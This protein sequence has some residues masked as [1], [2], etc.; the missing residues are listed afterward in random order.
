AAL[1]RQGARARAPAAPAHPAPPVAAGGDEAFDIAR[2]LA[3]ELGP[4]GGV[5][6]A[7]DDFQY[8]VE[9]VF[10]QFKKGV[11]ETVKPED[12]ETH[13]DLGIAYKEMGL[14]DDAIHEFEVAL[15]GHSKKKEV[16]CLSMIGLCHGSRGDHRA[17][18]E[19]FRRALRSGALTA[20]SAKA[21]HYELAAA[22]EALGQAEQALWYL[23]KIAKVDP[24]YRDAGAA[25]ARLGGGPGRPPVDLEA[26]A[27]VRAAAG[28]PRP[29]AKKNIGYV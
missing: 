12:T 1:E 27:A 19:V 18:V 7:T 11:A 14:L 29:G 16:D 15:T 3:E 22:H 21:I 13:Y 20:D 9:D 26:R 6:S 25:T 2:E 17:A 24:G 8:S 10:S 23:Q 5:G 4:P 28:P